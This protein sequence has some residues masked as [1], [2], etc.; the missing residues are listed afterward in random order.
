MAARE[1]HGSVPG[2]AVLADGNLSLAFAETAH[3][4]D[5]GWSDVDFTD[6]YPW[7]RFEFRT[8]ST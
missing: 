4:I 6:A 3:P 1:P 5:L 8:V 7:D 2:E